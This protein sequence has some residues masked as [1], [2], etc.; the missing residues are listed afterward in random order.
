MHENLT[1]ASSGECRLTTGDATTG[2]GCSFSDSDSSDSADSE[3]DS[4][5]DA[6]DPAPVVF[7]AAGAGAG[8]A[9]GVGTGAEGAAVTAGD[10]DVRLKGT[11]QLSDEWI[12]PGMT[13]EG[14]DCGC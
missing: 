4:L 3:S 7:D 5:D 8:A 9:V 11:V 12:L 1:L 14:M 2:G 13:I 6:L 10:S